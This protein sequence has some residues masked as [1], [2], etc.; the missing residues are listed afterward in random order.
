MSNLALGK[1]YFGADTSEEAFAPLDAFVEAGGNS[2]DTADVYTGSLAEQIVRR[3]LAARPNEVTDRVV[4]AT[5][6]R[7]TTGADINTSDC[8]AATST[9]H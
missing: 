9:G 8:P 7:F 1:M 2:I 4:L 3:W 5:T 6:G